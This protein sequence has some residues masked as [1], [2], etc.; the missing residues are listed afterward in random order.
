MAEDAAIK[1]Q[2][3][4]LEDAKAPRVPV[5][6]PRAEKRRRAVIGA[7]MLLSLPS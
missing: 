1:K 5:P 2:D 3:R 6:M 4:S 7:M